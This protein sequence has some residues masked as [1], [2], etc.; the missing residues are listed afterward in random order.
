MLSHLIVLAESAVRMV[1]KD[2]LIEKILDG[3]IVSESAVAVRIKAAR[4]AISEDGK[5]QRLICTIHGKG[6]RFVLYLADADALAPFPISYAS[7]RQ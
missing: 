6:L 2:E 5:S 3:R 4:K 7:T 1:S